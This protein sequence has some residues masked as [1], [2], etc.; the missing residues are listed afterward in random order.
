MINFVFKSRNESIIRSVVAI[1]AGVL[2]I[3]KPDTMATY[4]VY[5]IASLFAISAVVSFILSLKDKVRNAV[6]NN[7]SIAN[8]LLTLLVSVLLFV[9]APVV[10]D[11]IIFVI[12]GLLVAF[13]VVQIVTLLSVLKVA[14]IGFGFFIAPIG[15]TALGILI[16][17]NP[18]TTA[19]LI[20][21]VCGIAL[22]CYG[23]SELLSYWR[24]QKAKTEFEKEMRAEDEV[25]EQ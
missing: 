8:S 15:V 21:V 14:P 19:N 6:A 7:M 22:C 18:F 3:I 10:A 24:F 11:F 13:G 4:F 17:L 16:I 5:V 2:L 20:M 23:V 12:G 9:Y 25:D 1:L